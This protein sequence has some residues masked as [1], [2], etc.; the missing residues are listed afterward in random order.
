MNDTVKNMK[1]FDKGVPFD[2]GY[3]KYAIYFPE[4]ITPFLEELALLKSP[5]QKKFKLSTAEPQI[6]SLINNCAAFYL[7]CILW[8]AFIHHRFKDEPKD[9]IN[10]PMENLTKKELKDRDYTDEIEFIFQLI[11]HLD[12]DFKYFLKKPFQV[13]DQIIEIFNVYNEFTKLNKNFSNIKISSDVKLPKA[14][15][16]FEKL[17]N[18]KLDKL[19]EQIEQIISSGN[20]EELLKIGFYK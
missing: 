10:N 16:H 8:G 3:S 18:K 19:Y 11:A 7:G 13:D 6:K 4:S 5:H 20:I 17:D 2:P 14:V 12:K 9:V 15:K 1:K